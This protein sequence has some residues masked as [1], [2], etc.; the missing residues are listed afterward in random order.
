MVCTTRGGETST[1]RS[2]S[3]LDPGKENAKTTER[4]GGWQGERRKSKEK[5]EVFTPDEN[6]T[7]GKY[8]KI[9]TLGSSII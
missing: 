2:A 4:S 6:R 3:G 9:S 7:T 5:Q 1:V 8:F